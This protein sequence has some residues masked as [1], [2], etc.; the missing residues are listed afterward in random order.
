MAI[1]LTKLKIAV[2]DDDKV[3]LKVFSSM[4]KQMKLNTDFFQNSAE[5][6]NAII[7]G[8]VRYDL[9]I[10]DIVMPSGDGVAFARAIRAVYPNLPIMFMTGYANEEKRNEALSLG[11]V[12]FLEKPFPLMDKLRQMITD[13]LERA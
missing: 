10:T 6:L 12:E 11:H 7:M 13:F 3:I 5:A 9:L 1:D 2:V 8:S 4:M